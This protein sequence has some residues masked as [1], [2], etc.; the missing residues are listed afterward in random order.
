[1]KIVVIYNT[2]DILCVELQ[3]NNKQAMS[4]TL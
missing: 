3:V 4:M 2:D 1:M